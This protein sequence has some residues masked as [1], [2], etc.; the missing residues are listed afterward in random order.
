MRSPSFKASFGDSP[1]MPDCIEF[2]AKEMPD[3]MISR[4]NKI[5]YV[6][7]IISEVRFPI[8]IFIS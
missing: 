6:V 4:E 2:A 1:A 7:I 8:I 5:P 3:M